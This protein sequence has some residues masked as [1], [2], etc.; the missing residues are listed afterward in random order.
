[1]ADLP[2]RG[3]DTRPSRPGKIR[4]GPQGRASDLVLCQQLPD[5]SHALRIHVQWRGMG[6]FS[7]D[8]DRLVPQASG[9]G[10]EIFKAQGRLAPITAVAHRKE[11]GLH[12][13]PLSLKIRT[14]LSWKNMPASSLAR[15]S[16]K[17]PSLS[18]IASA[19][20]TFCRASSW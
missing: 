7:R 18:L 8:H 10:D 11:R 13:S 14:G 5:P 1:M 3:R 2:F 6:P 16:P 20:L 12:E 19:L 15:S 9:V 17:T 4:V